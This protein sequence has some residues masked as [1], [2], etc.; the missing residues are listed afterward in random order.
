MVTHHFL[1]TRKQSSVD[2]RRMR[3]RYLADLAGT[4]LTLPDVPEWADPVWHLFVVR[5]RRRDDLQQSLREAGIGTLIHYP[6]PPHLSKAYLDVGTEPPSLPVTERLAGEI[7][8]LPMGPHLTRDDQDHV[9]DAIHA[10]APA[11][12]AAAR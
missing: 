6:I 8:S 1:A 4:A 7:F 3:P 10:H 5:S 11:T 12:E 9:I 2:D